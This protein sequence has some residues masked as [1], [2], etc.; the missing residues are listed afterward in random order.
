MNIAELV[1]QW[2]RTAKGERVAVRHDIPLD[3]EAAARLAALA[4]MYPRRP[5]EELLGDLVG[6]ALEA[7]ES[8]FPYEPG[9]RVIATD[10]Q[11]DPVYEDTGPTP[12]FL[13][14]ARKH[15]QRLQEERDTP[16]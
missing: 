8:S 4:E 14:L 10:E 9:T 3:I 6:A 12:R 7:V 16:A 13:A 1:S 11:G 2:E 5:L 15:L